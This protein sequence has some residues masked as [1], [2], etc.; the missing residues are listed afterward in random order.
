M[1]RLAVAAIMIL[2]AMTAA[3]ARWKSQYAGS[4]NASWFESQ[5]DCEGHSCCG[6]ADGEAFYGSYEMHP[7][8][9]VTLGSGEKIAACKVLKGANPTGHAIWWKSGT[10]TYCFSLGSGF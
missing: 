8:G 9:S 10:T 3:E 1:K 4:P 7:D 2:A 6:S 5:K